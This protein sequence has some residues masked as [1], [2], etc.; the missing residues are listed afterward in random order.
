MQF[1]IKIRTCYYYFYYYYIFKKKLY[2]TTEAKRK[3]IW[4]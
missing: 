1:R 2:L 3:S 4:L